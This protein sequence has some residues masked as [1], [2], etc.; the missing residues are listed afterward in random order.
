MGL[1]NKIKKG[2]RVS[3]LINQ[4][5]VAR[6]IMHQ[7][8]T[9]AHEEGVRFVNREIIHLLRGD[10]GL[11]GFHFAGGTIRVANIVAHLQ[12]FGLDPAFTLHVEGML[13]SGL[14]FFAVN[15]EVDDDF[16]GVVDGVRD[17]VPAEGLGGFIPGEDIIADLDQADGLITKL[18]KQD[19]PVKIV[20]F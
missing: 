6:T 4:P 11:N 3:T 20:L 10:F 2:I 14:E 15:R 16:I 17:F 18:K 5:Y 19:N 7:P 9:V 12:I 1:L 8:L 13:R